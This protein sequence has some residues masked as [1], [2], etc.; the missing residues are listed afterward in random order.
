[1][2]QGEKKPSA[3]R[4]LF[5]SPDPVKTKELLLNHI[6]NTQKINSKQWNFNFKEGQPME[7]RFEWEEFHNRPRKRV[8][9]D[10]SPVCG[11]SSMVCSN[12]F[13][14]KV[15]VSKSSSK[16]EKVLQQ[17]NITD[18]FH[19]K[20]RSPYSKPHMKSPLQSPIEFKENN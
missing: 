6:N 9:M 14:K 4:C 15:Q 17:T 16:N 1:M 12:Y 10:K 2:I 20:S 18:Y 7:G 13:K 5:G 19:R 8:R 11:K 3:K